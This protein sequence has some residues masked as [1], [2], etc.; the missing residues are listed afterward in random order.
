MHHNLGCLTKTKFLQAWLL[1]LEE[2]QML[3]QSSKTHL[4][5]VL[6][7][8][9]LKMQSLI[10]ITNS[11]SNNSSNN[12]DQLLVAQKESLL[13]NNHQLHQ[14]YLVQTRKPLRNKRHIRKE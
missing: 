1:C 6:L 4:N 8:I 10:F 9:M 13:L 7:D 5:T 14:I 11:N 2:E 12:K 3:L